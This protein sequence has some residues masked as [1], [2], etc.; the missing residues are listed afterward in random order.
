MKKV[1]APRLHKRRLLAGQELIIEME[2]QAHEKKMKLL[3]LQIL[4]EE[5]R[6]KM[7]KEY[8]VAR[9][10][11]LAKQNYQMVQHVEIIGTR[12][13]WMNNNS[14]NNDSIIFLIQ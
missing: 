8:Y 3:D 11:F 6:I 14:I 1:V 10:N 12:A 4:R 9:M 5:A 7:D 2:E 13:Y